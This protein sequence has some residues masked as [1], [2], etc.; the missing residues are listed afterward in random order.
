[1]TE[2]V[3]TYETGGSSPPVYASDKPK[4][5]RNAAVHPEFVS[6]ADLRAQLD[7]AHNDINR[8]KRARLID[9]RRH[10]VVV[11]S[12]LVV[13]AADLAIHAVNGWAL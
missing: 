6:K 10:A 5:R 8:Q 9:R 11:A 1:M 12:F 2:N 7:H 4:P 3:A 13:F